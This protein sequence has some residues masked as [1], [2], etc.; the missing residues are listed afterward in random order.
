MWLY[1]LW[2]CEPFHFC[3]QI[4]WKHLKDHPLFGYY[5]GTFPS[6]SFSQ[7]SHKLSLVFCFPI[8]S[9]CFRAVK[10]SVNK[11]V[12]L[13]I[14][15]LFQMWDHVHVIRW[16]A[17]AWA[18]TVKGAMRQIFWCWKLCHV[19]A[20]RKRLVETDEIMVGGWGWASTLYLRFFLV[21]QGKRRPP[22][23]KGKVKLSLFT[24]HRQHAENSINLNKCF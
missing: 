5:Q 2:K 18:W 11:L 23:W 14:V 20:C 10:T 6:T 1:F 17:Q 13:G 16:S 22:H 4:A 21:W 12:P 19:S 8:W 9:H 15:V 3:L 24:D 7:G